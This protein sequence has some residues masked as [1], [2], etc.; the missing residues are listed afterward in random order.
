MTIDEIELYFQIFGYPE[1]DIEIRPGVTIRKE[2][3]EIFVTNTLLTLRAHSGNKRFMPYYDAL[4]KYY[5]II[6]WNQ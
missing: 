6:R 5:H 1:I 2:D 3:A 4:I